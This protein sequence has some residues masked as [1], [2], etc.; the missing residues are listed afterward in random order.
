MKDLVNS[1]GVFVVVV[2]ANADGLVLPAARR[3]SSDWTHLK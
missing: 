1:S 3:V 2:D